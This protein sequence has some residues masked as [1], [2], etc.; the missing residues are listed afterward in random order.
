VA[1][2]K[3]STDIRR[4]QIVAAALQ[5]MSESS[6]RRLTITAIA[7]RMGLAPSALYRH[8]RNRDAMMSA[9][10][11]HIRTRLY[12]NIE[13]VR[14]ESDDAVDRLRGLLD[15]HI[16]LIRREHGIPRIFFS[17]ELWGRQSERR[18]KM[19]RIV[20]G[21]LAEVEDIVREGQS[22]GTIRRDLDP[23]AAAGLFFGIVQP[24]ILLWH[25]SEG[26]F[27]IDGHVAATW[28]VFVE[29]VTGEVHA[30]C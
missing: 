19:F 15:R 21:Y 5:L 29:A 8:F 7:R 30:D 10:L 4:E 16:G 25:M 6:I 27:D 9:I 2:E 13:A 28:P 11:E 14:Q 17:D 24:A 23:G 22:R 26:S 18:R 12:R 20:T 1:A 3:L